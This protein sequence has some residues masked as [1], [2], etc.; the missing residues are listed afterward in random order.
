MDSGNRL[1]CWHKWKFGSYIHNGSFI[2][3]CTKCEKIRLVIPNSGSVKQSNI[4]ASGDV[5]GGDINK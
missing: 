1:F 5:A 4:R 3:S 2:Q